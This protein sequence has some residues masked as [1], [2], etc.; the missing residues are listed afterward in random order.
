MIATGWGRGFR[1]NNCRWVSWSFGAAVT[2]KSSN[3]GF[4]T[5]EIY[6]S[7]FW[8]LE[9]QEQGAGRFGVW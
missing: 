1:E 4:E 6:F 7:W 2:R 5:I 9:V 3:G 8:R